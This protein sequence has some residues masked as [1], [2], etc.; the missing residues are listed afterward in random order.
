MFFIVP[1]FTETVAA[2]TDGENQPGNKRK[3]FGMG[4]C[5]SRFRTQ[6]AYA[7]Q[8]V[9]ATCGRT[10]SATL[11]QRPS[12]PNPLPLMKMTDLIPGNCPLIRRF[13]L[14]ESFL[15]RLWLCGSAWDSSV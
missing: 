8:G 9:Y 1:S 3:S 13:T 7:C 4:A 15:T 10:K 6:L 2:I 11:K 5:R 12:R 14:N